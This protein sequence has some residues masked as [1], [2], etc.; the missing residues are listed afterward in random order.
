M[1]QQIEERVSITHSVFLSRLAIPETAT[2]ETFKQW[3]Q[4]IFL[5]IVRANASEILYLCDYFLY[6]PR[7]EHFRREKPDTTMR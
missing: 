4:A 3:V 5:L 6:N 1:M 7:S 2:S